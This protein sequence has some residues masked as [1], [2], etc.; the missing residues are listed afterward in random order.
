MAF[1]FHFSN[2]QLFTC[3]LLHSLHIPFLLFGDPSFATDVKH[4]EKLFDEK[5]YGDALPLYSQLSAIAPDE[6][7]KAQ[8]TLRLATCYL[9]RVN[10][11]QF[12]RCFLL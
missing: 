5:F 10:L 9:E 8:L 3:L 12:L 7:L 11:N 1:Y 2:W 6:E 4:A